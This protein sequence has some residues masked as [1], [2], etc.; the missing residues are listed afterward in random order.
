MVEDEDINPSDEL[1][2]WLMKGDLDFYGRYTL[3]ELLNDGAITRCRAQM[4]LTLTN[5][6]YPR[7][8]GLRF[9]SAKYSLPYELVKKMKCELLREIE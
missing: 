4:L 3:E 1:Y 9:F 2:Q 7:K 8:M 5:L 6:R